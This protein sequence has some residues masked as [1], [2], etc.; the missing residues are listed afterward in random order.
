MSLPEPVPRTIHPDSAETSR[1]AEDPSL[2][3]GCLRQF[4]PKQSD[5]RKTKFD[6]WSRE[7][8]RRATGI[9]VQVIHKGPT[10]DFFNPYGFPTRKRSACLLRQCNEPLPL[11]G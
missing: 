1:S 11:L 9:D 2:A 4:T 7:Y 6:N 5:H 3:F 10:G 8:L